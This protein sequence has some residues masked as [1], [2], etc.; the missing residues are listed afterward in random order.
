MDATEK[1]RVVRTRMSEALAE[2][3]GMEPQRSIEVVPGLHVR[4]TAGGIPVLRVHYSVIPERDPKLN[5]EWRARERKKYTSQAAWDREQEIVDEAGGGELVFAD[6]LV[7]Y[8]DKIVITDPRWRPDPCWNVVGG[9]D[10]GKTNPTV[11]VR[12]YV[13]DQGCLYFCGEYYEPGLEV[14]QHAPRLKAMEDIRKLRTVY[15]DPTI[16]DATM[17]QSNQPT[18][19]GTAQERAKSINDLY[20]E[21]GI[22]LFSPF[23]GDR[24][25]VSFAARLMT[26]WAGLEG[27]E[28]SVRIVCRNYAER[29][30]SGLDDWDCPNL[31]WELMRTRRVKLSTRQLLN[32]NLSEAIVD[33]DN[34]ARDVCKYVIMSHPEP[35]QKTTEERALEEIRPL[36]EA[37]DLTSA[38]IR[39]RQKTAEFTSRPIQIGRQRSRRRMYM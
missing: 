1:L 26:H 33:K 36:V 24:S 30:I 12:C 29:P 25:D 2:T 6:T 7:T 10:H 5:A 35:T 32:R 21:Q 20:V 8:W 28:P 37:G 4:R 16:F 34:H 11:L 39:Y 14:W 19:P 3:K 18:R 13:D 17:Q 23:S 31:L 38:L 9:F 27:R 15:A 22:E